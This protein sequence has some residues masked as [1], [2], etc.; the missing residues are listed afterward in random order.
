MPEA[1]ASLY[2]F[3]IALAATA[4]WLAIGAIGLYCGIYAIEWVR[5]WFA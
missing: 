2:D 1:L 5:R 3:A 4:A